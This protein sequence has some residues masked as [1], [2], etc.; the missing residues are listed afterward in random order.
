MDIDPEL[1]DFDAFY[2]Q[3]YEI[4]K[5]LYEEKFVYSSHCKEL[6]DELMNSMIEYRYLLCAG[7]IMNESLS[8]H[9]SNK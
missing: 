9:N 2:L 1:Y 5:E 8:K 4:M 6:L 7:V 3:S